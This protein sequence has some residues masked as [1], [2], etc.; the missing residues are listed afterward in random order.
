MGNEGAAAQADA[1]ELALALSLAGGVSAGCWSAGVL[2]FLRE[3]LD[4]WEAARDG[5]EPLAPR[6][7]V[8][9]HG[10]AGASS[11]AHAAALLAMGLGCDFPPVRLQ[12]GA[13]NPP[14][15]EHNP[16]FL[17]WVAG[18]TFQRDWLDTRDGCA[19]RF[20]SLLDGTCTLEIADRVL[21][22]MGR[23]PPRAPRGWIAT[24]LRLRFTVTHL[25]G[26]LLALPG[27]AA[28]H[29]FRLHAD[30]LRFAVDG[31]GTV[32]APAA[33]HDEC[34]LALPH[35]REQLRSEWHVVGHAAAASGAFPVLLPAQQVQWP[36][37]SYRPVRLVTPCQ[38]A[39]VTLD[40]A[41]PTDE[42]EP[43]RRT[44]FTAADGGVLVND[45]VD[46]AADTLP[47]ER[48]PQPGRPGRFAAVLA[49]HP[50][51]ARAMPEPPPSG[52]LRG[53]APHRLF[54]ALCRAVLDDAQVSPIDVAAAL[55]PRRPQRF[56]IAPA[57]ED[58]GAPAE[59]ALAGTAL[60]GF[61]G[62]L[63]E[64]YRRHDFQLGRCNAQAALWRQLTLPETHPL[65]EGWTDEQKAFHRVHVDGAA[66]LPIIPLMPPLRSRA[67]L[68][69]RWPAGR[70][71]TAGLAPAVRRRL[72]AVVQ[73]LLAV[74]L[75]RRALWRWLLHVLCRW[76]LLG[77]L[78][79]A[80]LQAARAGLRRHGL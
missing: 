46:L 32:R 65:F 77:R 22:T 69:L 49:V 27:A 33:A 68:P 80:A 17:G 35:R 57:R 67:E 3:A 45:P 40:P 70:D 18:A 55:D 44:E 11:G 8:V 10:L 5:G 58:A 2:D 23:L 28:P 38:S 62:Y 64:A 71:A 6:H 59:P 15:A 19:R 72:D 4:A 26:V 73:G 60:G 50:L 31:L 66:A 51:P 12:D 29:G 78:S 34:A 76:L 52:R 30:A 25:D 48:A 37:S 41:W 42:P 24:P 21:D 61:A 14:E 63:D 36:L 20:T 75:P 53:S 16:L 39:P 13:A 54:G 1:P 43:S 74:Y 56:M 7:R 9:L 47:P 79:A